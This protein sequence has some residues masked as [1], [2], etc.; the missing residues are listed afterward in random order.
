MPNILQTMLHT[1]LAYRISCTMHLHSVP[2]SHEIFDILIPNNTVTSQCWIVL[3]LPRLFSLLWWTTVS[4]L[5]SRLP[6]RRVQSSIAM[7][8]HRLTSFE[9]QTLNLMKPRC[10]ISHEL[11]VSLN[12]WSPCRHILKRVHTEANQSNL[13]PCI[14]KH[15][16][17]RK[18]GHMPD[19]LNALSVDQIKFI[20]LESCSCTLSYWCQSGNSR[21]RLLILH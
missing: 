1:R 13:C 6:E 5:N 21:L 14:A 3:F 17:C 8:Q 12:S 18:A 11:Q 4:A 16:F 19:A 15:T 2:K 7:S 9:R 10:P 20:Q